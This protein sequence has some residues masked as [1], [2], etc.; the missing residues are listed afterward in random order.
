MRW[1]AYVLFMVLSA[2]ERCVIDTEKSPYKELPLLFFQCPCV[3]VMEFNETPWTSIIN[4]LSVCPVSELKPGKMARQ[5]QRGCSVNL[6]CWFLWILSFYNVK[7]Y[8]AERV[9]MYLCNILSF[10]WYGQKNAKQEAMFP[11]LKWFF[12]I[13]CLCCIVESSIPLLY[14]VQ[15][16]M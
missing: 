8:E 2:W 15:E 3:Q 4:H 11:F 13:T 10:L 6:A 9:K 5:L 16:N 7:I 12:W 1:E 14:M